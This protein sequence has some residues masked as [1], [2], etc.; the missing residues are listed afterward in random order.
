MDRNTA[1]ALL[2]SSVEDP[3]P[4]PARHPG[5][6]ADAETFGH[7]LRN[8][9]E[10]R[11]VTLQ[12]MRETT[13]LAVPQLEAL[14][15]GDIRDW[16]RGI[17]RRAMVRA[18]ASAIGLDPEEILQDFLA[19]FPEGPLPG[20]SFTNLEPQRVDV[21]EAIGRYVARIQARLRGREA[22]T[23][24]AWPGLSLTSLRSVGGPVALVLVGYVG[25]GGEL[26]VESAARIAETF[27][28][29]VAVPALVRTSPPVASAAVHT[30]HVS[31]STLESAT[32]GL[33]SAPTPAAADDRPIP[34]AGKLVITSKPTG[35]RVTVNGV[36]WGSTPMTIRYVPLGEKR[37]RLSKDGYVTA[38]RDIQLTPNRPMQSVQLALRA[39]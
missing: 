4:H 15:R 35:A 18:Y 26:P 7:F 24:P 22:P 33:R 9:R 25:G 16:P 3:P 37:I 5:R 31:R 12:Q 29:A 1:V 38:E 39:R 10:G 28:T 27:R 6:F 8:H 19:V 23:L 13:K 11:N 32:S 17:Y 34:D 14:E 2:L 36:G 20:V 21:R 30:S